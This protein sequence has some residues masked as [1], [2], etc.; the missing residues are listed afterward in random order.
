MSDEKVEEICESLN[1]V[2]NT[3][4]IITTSTV[5]KNFS[6]SVQSTSEMSCSVVSKDTLLKTLLSTSIALSSSV[7]APLS[8]GI[9]TTVPL[10][11]MITKEVNDTQLNLKKI[12]YE[13]E[14]ESLKDK[15]Q[16]SSVQSVS[17]KNFADTQMI[18]DDDR[19]VIDISDEEIEGQKKKKKNKAKSMPILDF[20][21]EGNKYTNRMPK[22]ITYSVETT[23]I[24]SSCVKIDILTSTGSFFN[25]DS[26]EISKLATSISKHANISLNDELNILSHEID[27]QM[28]KKTMEILELVKEYLGNEL[29]E[30]EFHSKMNDIGN[31]S[32]SDLST[33]A[34]KLI[35][36][37]KFEAN[38][39]QKEFMRMKFL[40]FPTSS[41]DLVNYF[42]NLIPSM[43]KDRF[44]N[45]IKFYE[46][47]IKEMFNLNKTKILQYLIDF[48]IKRKNAQ[49]DLLNFNYE[50]N[51]SPNLKQKV[52]S[53]FEM[54][55]S[56]QSIKSER[57]IAK[58]HD[59]S[60]NFVIRSDPI[61]L[62]AGSTF[63][64]NHRDVIKCRSS[65]C[66]Q[67]N[68]FEKRPFDNNILKGRRIGRRIMNEI[69]EGDIKIQNLIEVNKQ[70]D[71]P[72]AEIKSQIK[73]IPGLPVLLSNVSS[74]EE[75]L[76]KPQFESELLSISKFSKA[77][78]SSPILV[79]TPS[80]S[81]PIHKIIKPQIISQQILQRAFSE[82]IT[83]ASDREQKK[84]L[85]KFPISNFKSSI[86]IQNNVF[87]SRQSFEQQLGG[88]NSVTNN[89]EPISNGQLSM[90][91]IKT[92][93]QNG[94]EIIPTPI[95]RNTITTRRKTIDADHASIVKTPLEVRKVQSFPN[96]IMNSPSSLPTTKTSLSFLYE[97]SQLNKQ[98]SK[99]LK[100]RQ[101]CHERIFAPKPS[102]TSNIERHFMN[103]MNGEYESKKREAELKRM[104]NLALNDAKALQF[105]H[106]HQDIQK[107]TPPLYTQQ[108]R[109]RFISDNSSELP[110][111][112][113]QTERTQLTPNSQKAHQSENLSPRALFRESLQNTLMHP[114][115]KP[116]QSPIDYQRYQ[117]YFER[118]LRERGF[119]DRVENLQ[120]RDA[121]LISI[122]RPLE[123]VSHVPPEHYLQH[124]EPTQSNAFTSPKLTRPSDKSPR[125]HQ[126]TPIMTND[127][128][129]TLVAYNQLQ[130]LHRD[131][132]NLTAQ[133]YSEH[134]KQIHQFKH[135][136]KTSLNSSQGFYQDHPNQ[137]LETRDKSYKNLQQS[138]NQQPENTTSPRFF[139]SQIHDVSNDK[140]Q[141]T[142]QRKLKLKAKSTKY[143]EPS[144]LSKA[145]QTT[146]RSTYYTDPYTMTA[147]KKP[148]TPT[149]YNHS[150]DRPIEQHSQEQ[151]SA[152]Y[153]MRNES[154]MNSQLQ[155]QWMLAQHH[156]QQQQH[157]QQHLNLINQ[158]ARPIPR[159][160]IPS[161][162]NDA[163][164]NGIPANHNMFSHN[165]LQ[166]FSNQ[167]SDFYRR[168]FP[169]SF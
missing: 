151:L 29:S 87:A 35:K 65:P 64:T 2:I 166:T 156:Q 71:S 76:L 54:A 149:V 36:R 113:P 59:T 97:Q 133:Q 104:P 41:K 58:L 1:N 144:Q 75:Q 162:F 48:M 145:Y 15:D 18:D 85:E 63:M 101:S 45:M 60:Y 95:L 100:R 158:P 62:T 99:I 80:S 139:S 46:I 23:G 51:S 120:D 77:D 88:S 90:N 31:V 125:M 68:I 89:R 109:V 103:F 55:D 106:K 126:R 50:T 8:T 86:S 7:I 26:V 164:L 115:L 47:I 3:S 140:E 94:T 91:E 10:E 119:V 73:S 28:N 19:L 155:Y 127:E 117:L 34:K 116:Y 107:P 42:K 39:N 159:P 70:L 57:K 14:N 83:D 163:K 150:Q 157:Q 43:N 132:S 81:P 147:H 92:L 44:V 141:Q 112:S 53:T 169:K 168:Y 16:E 52:S 78:S 148:P 105:H 49:L 146:P 122:N 21:I 124:S 110:Q 111:R 114:P 118:E 66:V 12:L 108:K 5:N 20:G 24:S 137:L 33:I 154:S 138:I 30:V 102:N 9:S 40:Q 131:P 136:Q 72:S 152:F 165:P 160:A 84:T 37:Q 74:L 98:A 32:V 134:L 153:N 93:N 67:N 61:Y 13:P 38:P 129:A 17:Q 130:S 121:N 56:T 135:M 25:S 142:L 167:Q 27:K 96:E 161:P 69:N 123:L 79:D 6:T 4:T 82:R 22:S 128:K 11:S 143:V